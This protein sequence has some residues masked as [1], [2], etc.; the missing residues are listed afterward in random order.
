MRNNK[1]IVDSPH[2]HP[3]GLLPNPEG[4]LT[5]FKRSKWFQTW[6]WIWG[7]GL[8]DTTTKSTHEGLHKGPKQRT[9]PQL[10]TQL[11][12]M[13]N[14]RHNQTMQDHARLNLANTTLCY[15]KCDWNLWLHRC[16]HWRASWFMVS[17]HCLCL[18]ERQVSFIWGVLAW[19]HW[20]GSQ[21]SE[22][23]WTLW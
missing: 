4:R 11:T 7:K 23:V 19:M 16:S 18:W 14:T 10:R 21:T 17:I 9:R 2:T 20:G 1:I 8:P 15:S 5:H 13:T 22:E 6:D 12:S 3:K